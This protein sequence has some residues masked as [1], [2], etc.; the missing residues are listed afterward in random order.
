MFAST[1]VLVTPL[2]EP[3]PSITA[4]LLGNPTP[5]E[6]EEPETGEPLIELSTPN[7]IRTRVTAVKGRR[8]RPLDDGGLVKT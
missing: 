8:P 7:G 3:S 5:P 1:D 4:H 2:L 6:S